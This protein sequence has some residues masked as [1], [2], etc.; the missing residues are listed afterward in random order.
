MT[1]SV[2][3]SKYILSDN[4]GQALVLTYHNVLFSLL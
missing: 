4:N 3:F 2:A 1:E